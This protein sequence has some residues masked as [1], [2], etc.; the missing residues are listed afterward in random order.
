MIKILDRRFRLCACRL[1]RVGLETFSAREC[2]SECRGLLW[3]QSR[4]M[5]GRTDDG[6]GVY[7]AIVLIAY[8]CEGH[9]QMPMLTACK[10]IEKLPLYV[11]TQP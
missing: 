1:Y 6:R 8:P 7:T 9:V 11:S 2:A 5:V 3:R 4:W 10:C